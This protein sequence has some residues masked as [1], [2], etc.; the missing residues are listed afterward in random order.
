[1][2]VGENICGLDLIPH[3]LPAQFHIL[4]LQ[5]PLTLKRGAMSRDGKS[6]KDSTDTYFRPKNSAYFATYYNVCKTAY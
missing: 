6:V 1:M 4:Y 2:K 3:A 5:F